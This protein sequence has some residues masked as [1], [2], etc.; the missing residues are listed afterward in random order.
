M[1]NGRCGPQSGRAGGGPGCPGARVGVGAAPRRR[2]GI[3]GG[4][5]AWSAGG[6]GGGSGGAAGGAARA[7]VVA[8]GRRRA[9]HAGPDGGL[10]GR[11][12]GAGAPGRRGGGVRLRR[13]GGRAPEPGVAAAAAGAGVRGRVG[14]HRG[15]EPG[16]HGRAAD[17]GRA[18]HGDALRHARQAARVRVRSSGQLRVAAAAGVEPDEPAGVRGDRTELRRVRRADGAA[19]AGG[20][21]HRVRGLPL[22]V[23]RTTCTRRPATGSVPAAAGTPWFA[24]GVLAATL[25][26]FGLAEPAGVQPGLDRRRRSRGAGRPPRLRGGTVAE[27]GRL[28]RAANLPFCGFVFALGV[29]VLAVRAG[30]VGDAVRALVPLGRRLRRPAGRGRCWRRCWRTC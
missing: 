30:P 23:R 14:G 29:V 17:A 28:L 1:T 12:A 13:R 6:G 9:G 25:V 4:A 3:R 20:D 24:L 8:R 21:R 15:A 19:L 7:G 5:A 22:G 2:A 11:G 26:G 10:P 18:G 16:R 27:A